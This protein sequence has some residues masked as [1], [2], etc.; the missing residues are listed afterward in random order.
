[1]SAFFAE[2]GMFLLKA[3]TIVLAIIV[4]IGFGAA[5][6]RKASQEGLEVENINKKHK[7]LAGGL[8]K[9]VRKAIR[10]GRE[11]LLS[12]FTVI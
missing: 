6:S 4:V 9:A 3:V 11:H 12:I 7:A 8:R 5:S 2:Y 10:Q 1:M